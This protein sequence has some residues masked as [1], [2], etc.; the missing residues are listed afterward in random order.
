MT[1]GRHG[2]ARADSTELLFEQD[3]VVLQLHLVRMLLE[4]LRLAERVR[5]DQVP[6][7]PALIRILGS[8]WLFGASRRNNL[9][10]FNLEYGR[11]VTVTADA[12]LLVAKSAAVFYRS[13]A[14]QLDD[15]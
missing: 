12:R 6:P 10:A 13:I 1:V 4:Y 3:G 8:C 9:A 2:F 14:R 11:R 15:L 7:Y 5:L